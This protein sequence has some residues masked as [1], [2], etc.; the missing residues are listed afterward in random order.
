MD[1]GPT[2]RAEVHRHP[3]HRFHQ[4]ALPSTRRGHS[5][6]ASARNIPASRFERDLGERRAERAIKHR[7]DGAGEKSR[8]AAISSARAGAALARHLVASMQ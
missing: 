8:G 1:V 3:G 2:C 7:A 4:V 6:S 5:P